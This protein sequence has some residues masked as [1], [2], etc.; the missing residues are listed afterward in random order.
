MYPDM[1]PVPCGPLS[2]I[3]CTGAQ[4]APDPE[5]LSAIWEIKAIDHHCHALPA[6]QPDPAEALRPDPLGRAPFPYPVR[7]RVSNPEYGAAWRALYGYPHDDM[8]DD[9]AREALQA[10][11]H[12]MEEKG[13]DYPS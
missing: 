4:A 13:T 11:L 9:H 1:H 12:L 8:A 10:K 6:R 2:P 3:P 7:L 5:L